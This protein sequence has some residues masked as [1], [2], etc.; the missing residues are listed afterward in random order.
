MD[1]IKS[2]EIAHALY[3]RHGDKAEL[4]AAQQENRFKDAGDKHEAAR[5]RAIR[6][7]IRQIRGANQG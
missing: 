6:S 2:T 1:T 7:S 4:E 3:R 5:W